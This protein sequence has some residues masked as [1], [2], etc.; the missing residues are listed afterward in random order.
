MYKTDPSIFEGKMWAQLGN[1]CWIQES[2]WVYH[3][4]PGNSHVPFT[5][6]ASPLESDSPHYMQ[7]SP[8][9]HALLSRA[10]WGMPS[11]PHLI[12]PFIVGSW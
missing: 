9:T 7:H 10:L 12:H 8:I 3:A 6:F 2:D 5:W 1:S 11:Q 4:I